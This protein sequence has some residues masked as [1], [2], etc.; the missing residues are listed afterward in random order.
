MCEN[1][2][3]C[4]Y[5]KIAKLA[6]QYAVV[7]IEPNRMLLE[8]ALRDAGFDVPPFCLYQGAWKLRKRQ[9]RRTS[10]NERQTR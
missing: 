1:N 2:P 4:K 3:D 9:R 6:A 5:H 10:R 7:R 8:H